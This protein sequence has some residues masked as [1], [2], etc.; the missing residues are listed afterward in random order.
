M[1]YPKSFEAGTGSVTYH[2]T[3]C[4]CVYVCECVLRYVISNV[5]AHSC[6]MCPVDMICVYTMKVSGTTV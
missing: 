6:A 3:L 2:N 5:L 1:L 4:V